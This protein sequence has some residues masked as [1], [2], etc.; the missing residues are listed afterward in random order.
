[1]NQLVAKAAEKGGLKIS[2]KVSFSLG[3]AWNLL[4]FEW[5]ICDMSEWPC[6]VWYWCKASIDITVRDCKTWDAENYFD[7]VASNSLSDQ[8]GEK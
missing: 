8:C 4:T 1:M 3:A 6:K 7:K 5:T 2:Q